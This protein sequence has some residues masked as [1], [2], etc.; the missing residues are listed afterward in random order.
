MSEERWKIQVCPDCG[1]DNPY[2]TFGT[3]HHY[4]NVWQP[5]S[6]QVVAVDVVPASELDTLRERVEELEGKL[7]EALCKLLGHRVRITPGFI[8]PAGMCQRCGRRMSSGP[9]K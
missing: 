5:C 6:G 1:R 4:N 3:K 7:D 2:S 9:T 8:W